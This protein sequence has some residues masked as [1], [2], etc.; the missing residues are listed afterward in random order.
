MGAEEI[1]LEEDARRYAPKLYLLDT[2]ALLWATNKPEQL[3][4]PRAPFGVSPTE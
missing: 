4:A 3:S 2:C 1:D